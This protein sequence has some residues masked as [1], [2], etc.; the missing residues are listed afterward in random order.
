MLALVTPCSTFTSILRLTPERS[1]SSQ[2][3]ALRRACTRSPISDTK[4]RSAALIHEGP[5][6]RHGSTLPPRTKRGS[7]RDNG[8]RDDRHPINYNA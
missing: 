3:R 5:G 2:P 1:A 6:E 4:A 8:N 7:E